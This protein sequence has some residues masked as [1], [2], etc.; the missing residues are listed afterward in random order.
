MVTKLQGQRVAVTGGAGF[1]GSHLVDKLLELGKEVVVFDNFATGRRENLSQH[2]G[3][4]NLTILDGDVRDLPTLQDAFRGIDVVFHLATHCVRLSLVDP[5]TNHDVNSTGTL[6]CLMAA[7]ANGVG[8]FVYC[9]SSE[10]YGGAAL[11]LGPKGGLLSEESPKHPTT[12][13][14]ASKL[15]GEHY[16]LAFHQTHGL[17]AVVARPFNAFGPRS[18][19]DG[20]YGE[21]IPRFTV[22][23]KAGVEPVI[24]GDGLQTRDFTYVR[25]TAEGLIAAAASDELLGRSIN[26]ARGEEVTIKALAESIRRLTGS[27]TQPRYESD[28]PGDIRRLGADVTLAKRLFPGL[29][30]TGL[31]E[32]LRQYL[33]WLESQKIDF[34]GAARSLSDRNW[35]DAPQK[36]LRSVSG[37]RA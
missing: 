8:R 1:I 14:G 24:F 26:L 13:Y 23:F 21:V 15:V 6:N 20:P 19:L 35:T 12:V 30:L 7:K 4:S 37:T 10:V 28:R 16:S 2:L 3:N 11:S 25:D 31:D 27:K 5:A 29:F 32:G 17:K 36:R 33:R 34:S 22:W 18:H 9:S